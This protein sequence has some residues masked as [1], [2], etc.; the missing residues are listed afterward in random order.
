M[1]IAGYMHDLGKLAVPAEIL[2]KPARLNRGEYDVVR[3]HTFYTYRI[4][5][6]IAP[7]RTINAWAAFHHE[8]LDGSGYPFHL[9]GKDL[10]LGSQIMAVA[11]VFTALAEDR[12]YRAGMKRSAALKILDGMT[13]AAA[14]NGEVVAMLR[15]HYDELDAVRVQAQADARVKYRDVETVRRS[16]HRMPGPDL[17]ISPRHS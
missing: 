10:P 15:K 6:P 14:L 4:L 5:E 1:R 7:L 9:K 17:R 2:D 12:P 11:D 8:R 13:A 3:H 16:A